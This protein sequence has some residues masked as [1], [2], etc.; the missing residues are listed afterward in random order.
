MPA[1]R[2]CAEDA[3]GVQQVGI[4]V[5]KTGLRGAREQGQADDAGGEGRPLPGE[6]QMQVAPGEGM[7]LPRDAGLRPQR[8]QQVVAQHGRRQNQRQQNQ[9][10]PYATQGH[11]TAR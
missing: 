2:L 8:G 10:F 4:N 9:A 11:A 3:G 6:N 5:G 7:E 1:I